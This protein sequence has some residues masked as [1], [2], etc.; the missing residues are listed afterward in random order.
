MHRQLRRLSAP[1]LAASF[2][3][4]A[5]GS[6][7]ES[8]AATDTTGTAADATGTSA[9]PTASTTATSNSSK[10]AT[11]AAPNNPTAPTTA[12]AAAEQRV[13][14]AFANDGVVGGPKTTKLRTG[15]PVVVVIRSDVAEEVHLHGY[16]I[17]VQVQAGTPAELRFEPDIPGVFE[18][19]FHGSGQKLGELEIR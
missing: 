9:D 10:V 7:T 16:D 4:A 18:I 17:E 19:E 5:C 2:L 8:T 6:D 13:E 12:A 3:L 15:T 11:S 1:A 14:I